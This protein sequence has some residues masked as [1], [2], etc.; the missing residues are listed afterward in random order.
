MFE[1]LIFS[2]KLK[3]SFLDL[4]KVKKFIVYG[5]NVDC[6]KVVEGNFFIVF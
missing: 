3:C 1:F 4:R 2:R 6:R 5:K